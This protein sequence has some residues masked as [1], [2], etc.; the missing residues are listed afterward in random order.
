MEKLIRALTALVMRPGFKGQKPAQ[1]RELRVDL[2]DA[3]PAI[4]E[5]AAAAAASYYNVDLGEFS[6]FE[7]G[8]G[9]VVSSLAATIE[10]SAEDAG[11]HLASVLAAAGSGGAPFDPART[12]EL[13]S[14]GPVADSLITRFESAAQFFAFIDDK[15]ADEERPDLQALKDA[16]G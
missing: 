8:A 3:P 7:N 5:L 4:R 14:D 15:N 10:Q 11:I 12:L 16:A 9:G 6:M 13:G 1:P 2:G